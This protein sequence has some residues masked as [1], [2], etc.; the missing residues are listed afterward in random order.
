M[1]ESGSA[2]L[3][4]MAAAAALGAGMLDASGPASAQAI[5][6]LYLT[7]ASVTISANPPPNT[8]T[9][10]SG[11]PITIG[12]AITI[13]TA[14][15][16]GGGSPIMVTANPPVAATLPSP[17]TS[18]ATPQ[19]V[20]RIP[21]PVI[22]PALGVAPIHQRGI[23]VREGGLVG[24]VGPSSAGSGVITATLDKVN[25]GGVETLAVDL[26]GDG[27]L[28]LEVARSVVDAHGQ[29]LSAR[30]RIVALTASTARDVVDGVT[31]ARSRTA[32]HSVANEGGVIV[33]GGAPSK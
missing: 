10:G 3:K 13:S 8:I 18:T 24:L 22:N 12:G 7:S 27:L 31:N 20:S 4:G 30:N 6:T 15:S 33:F 21:S 11:S 16:N 14:G 25:I 32:A 19:P 23:T 26:A 2:A 29:A 17:S 28:R 1:A 5:G 9:V